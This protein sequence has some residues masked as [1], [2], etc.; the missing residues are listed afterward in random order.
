MNLIHVYIIIRKNPTVKFKLEIFRLLCKL[1]KN[2]VLKLEILE[3]ISM[4]LGSRNQKELTD[5]LG[6]KKS[7]F[8]DWK[9]GKSNSYRKYLIEIAN[10]FEV[11]IDYLVYG[12]EQQSKIPVEAPK[13]QLTEDQERLLEMYE[14]LTDLEKGE[15]LGELKVMTKNRNIINQENVS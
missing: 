11:S 12:K 4:L 8:T 14:L 6:L 15:I 13:P 7:A 3:R 5:F 2:E 1:S 10:F 9:L